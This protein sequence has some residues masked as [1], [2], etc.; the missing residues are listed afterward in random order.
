[1]RVVAYVTHDQV[2]GPRIWIAMI[3]HSGE[4]HPVHFL[5]ATEKGVRAQAEAWWAAEL[6]KAGRGG[7]RKPKAAEPADEDFGEAI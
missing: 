2:P 3:E 1:M 6:A 5:G 7:K 4:Y